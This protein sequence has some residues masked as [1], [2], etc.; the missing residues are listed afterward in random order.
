MSSRK[1]AIKNYSYGN[2][3]ECNSLFVFGPIFPFTTVLLPLTIVEFLKTTVDIS[4]SDH[5][6]GVLFGIK[7]KFGQNLRHN[8]SEYIFYYVLISEMYFSVALIFSELAVLFFAY[9]N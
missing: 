3:F 8:F 2:I 6:C 4:R 9:Y 1:K 5:R 7:Y